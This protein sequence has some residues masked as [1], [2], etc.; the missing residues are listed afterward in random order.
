MVVH[1]SFQYLIDAAGPH[2]LFHYLTQAVSKKIIADHC[3]DTEVLTVA[4]QDTY[5]RAQIARLEI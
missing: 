2:L 1:L 3:I 4:D 5:C